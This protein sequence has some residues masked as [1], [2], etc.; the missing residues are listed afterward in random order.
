MIQ[1]IQEDVLRLY[2]NSMSFYISDLEKILHRHQGPTEYLL[3]KYVC[4]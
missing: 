1:S 4:V 2:A 3:Y